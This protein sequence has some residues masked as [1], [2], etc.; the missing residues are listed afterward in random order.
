MR[1]RVPQHPR[2]AS[3]LQA[4]GVLR[5]LEH[6]PRERGLYV[7]NYHRIGTTDGNVLD[8]ATFSASADSLHTQMTYLRRHFA[9]PPAQQVLESIQ[10]GHF[11]D[12]SVLVTFDDGYRDN[13]D[14]A[15]PVLRD[16]GVPGCFFV[17]SGY[18]DQPSLPWWDHVAYAVKRTSVEVL[19]LDYPE[20]LT[21]DLRTTRRAVV[22]AGILRAYKRARP[23]DGQ[24]FFDGFTA[25]TGVEVDGAAL[26]RDL[27]ASWDA[28]REMQAGGMTIGSHTVT[29]PVLASL[30]PEAQRRELTQSRER[31][32]EMLGLKPDLLAYPVGGPTAFTD[33]TQQL[34][35]EAGYRAAFSYFGGLNHA[36]RLAPYA[37]GRASVE[38]GESHAQFRLKA[39]TATVSRWR[40]SPA[41]GQVV[42]GG[43]NGRSR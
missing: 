10:R 2:V 31:I 6:L 5:A 7:L 43:V 33:T 23:L 1:P 36:E 37:I 3:L 41:R 32:G 22:T 12:P 14:L 21:F 17:V 35:R 24:R 13:Y 15:F 39:A 30:P 38:I 16:A 4:T 19:T 27:F 26:S 28:L 18:V 8:D 11:D 20:P 42:A 29:H 40:S 9:T 34:A 25:A